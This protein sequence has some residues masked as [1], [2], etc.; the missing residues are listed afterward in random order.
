MVGTTR[1]RVGIFLKKFREFGLIEVSNEH[2]LVIE[3]KMLEDYIRRTSLGERPDLS[4]IQAAGPVN[5]KPYRYL[6]TSST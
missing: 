6:P 2:C 5:P 3:E 4:T 1:P